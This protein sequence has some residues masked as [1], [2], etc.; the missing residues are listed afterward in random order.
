MAADLVSFAEVLQKKCPSA[1]L[2]ERTILTHGSKFLIDVSRSDR[3][4][5]WMDSIRRAV[6]DCDVSLLA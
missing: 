4:R 1:S 6:E 2:S 3:L 5:A